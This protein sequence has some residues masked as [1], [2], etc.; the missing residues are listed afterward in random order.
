MRE[1]Q[2]RRRRGE[3]AL[4]S[5]ETSA[6]QLC[7]VEFVLSTFTSQPP[8]L[9]N[10][11]EGIFGS[12][13]YNGTPASKPKPVGLV[14]VSLYPFALFGSSGCVTSQ[15]KKGTKDLL[16]LGRETRENWAVS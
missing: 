6:I 8:S 13:Q 1:R 15:K 10:E 16:T 12:I 11:M 4:N 5:V 7:R 14:L 2:R 9:L 3:S